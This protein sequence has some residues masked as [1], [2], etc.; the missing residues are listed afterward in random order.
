MRIWL[1]ECELSSVILLVYAAMT[2]QLLSWTVAIAF[3]CSV[4]FKMQATALFSLELKN[5]QVP[6]WNPICEKGL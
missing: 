6:T 4:T 3:K 2:I 5:P 1:L